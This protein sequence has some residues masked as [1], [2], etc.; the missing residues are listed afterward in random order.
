MIEASINGVSGNLIL[1]TGAPYLVLNKTYFR[2][3]FTETDQVAS[4]ITGKGGD[5]L[6]TFVKKFQL[7]EL[8]YENVEADITNLAQIEN[9]K[10]VKVLGLMGTNL[11]T[12][13][14]MLIDTRRDALILY[15]LDRQG[16]RFY[17]G[18]APQT[19]DVKIPFM[20]SNN[21]IYID[22]MIQ[23]KSLR[24]CFD[25]GAEV[26][27]LNTKV[28]KK[29]LDDFIVQRR[30]LLVGSGGQRA[31][32]INGIIKAAEIGGHSFA[33]MQTY[34]TPLG[35]LQRI[36]DNY[37]D[38]ILGYPLMFNGTVGINFKKKEFSMYLYG[39]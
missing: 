39:K 36:Y 7:Q 6:K 14:E 8:Y 15:K 21:I 28:N 30:S 33:T 32:V 38:G 4:G 17:R 20:L 9:S 16:E 11:F 37:F 3:G 34:L 18:D 22:G 29:V 2:K 13:F 5:V 19:A 27:V 35:E 12:E 10:G 23:E 1:D 24:F 25:S 26:N 31:E